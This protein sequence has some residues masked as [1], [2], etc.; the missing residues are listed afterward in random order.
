MILLDIKNA[1]WDLIV[2]KLREG[3]LQ[4]YPVTIYPT[5]LLKFRPKNA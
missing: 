2:N 4:G 1:F 5:G 3:K